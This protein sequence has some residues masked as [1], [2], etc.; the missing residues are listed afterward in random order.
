MSKPERRTEGKRSKRVERLVWRLRRGEDD[1]DS[2]KQLVEYLYPTVAKVL[3]NRLPTQIP[4][5][6]VAQQ[7]FLKVF[8]KLDQYRA[9]TPIEHWVSKIAVNTCLNAMRGQRIRREIRRA[10]LSEAED[11]ALDS[12]RA[13]DK[14]LDASQT[15]AARDLLQRLLECLTPKERMAVEL[16]ELEGYTSK[17]AAKLLN[18]SAVSV[19]VRVTRA[20]AKMRNHLE[21]LQSEDMC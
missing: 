1:H 8:T 21:T 9:E 12:L 10:D 18:S 4:V 2:A 20:R 3:H 19:R 17:E 16:T 13:D 6:D 5:D 15:L 11:A 7:V 14:Q